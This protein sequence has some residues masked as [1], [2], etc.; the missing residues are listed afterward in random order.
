MTAELLSSVEESLHELVVAS[1]HPSAHSNYQ[2]LLPQVTVTCLKVPNKFFLLADRI[3]C[4]KKLLKMRVP[5]F[6]KLVN[7]IVEEGGDKI[8]Y[9]ASKA[10]ER[11]VLKSRR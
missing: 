5:S 4:I 6:T 8:R 11:L 10:E 3:R 1:E 7:E 9:D 2:I